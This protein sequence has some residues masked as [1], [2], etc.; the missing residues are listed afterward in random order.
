MATAVVA[1]HE[2]RM[3]LSEMGVLDPYEYYL[4]EFCGGRSSG[5]LPAA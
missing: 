2:F 3:G 5:R 4:R 1:S